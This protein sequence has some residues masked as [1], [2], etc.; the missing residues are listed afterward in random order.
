MKTLFV[1]SLISVLFP[2]LAF[3]AAPRQATLVETNPGGTSAQNVSYT[4]LQVTSASNSEM[5]L[6]TTQTTQWR[7]TARLHDVKGVVLQYQSQDMSRVRATVYEVDGN[8]M[9]AIVTNVVMSCSEQG[10]QL[11]CKGVLAQSPYQN[12]LLLTVTL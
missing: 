9:G 8:S 6:E 2:A 12:E 11:Q 1:S 3:A 7:A 4:R 10:H 5:R